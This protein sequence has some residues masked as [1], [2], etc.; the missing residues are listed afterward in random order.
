MKA[1]GPVLLPRFRELIF[2]GPGPFGKTQ[3]AQ[4]IGCKPR[5][6]QFWTDSGLVSP[7]VANPGGRG[8]TR[9]YSKA[10]VAEFVVLRELRARDVSLA[11]AR[12]VLDR[13]R[14]ERTFEVYMAGRVTVRIPFGFSFS[15]EFTS[16]TVKAASGDRAVKYSPADIRCLQKLQREMLVKLADIE[17]QSPEKNRRGAIVTNHNESRRG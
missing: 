1:S 4:I 13:M 5:T 10:N 8:T 3:V 6:I 16:M 12:E 7:D 17:A 14:L 9:L 15:I 2:P 11:N